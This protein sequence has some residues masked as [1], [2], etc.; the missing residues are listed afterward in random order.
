M[1]HGLYEMVQNLPQ[2]LLP[3]AAAATPPFAGGGNAPEAHLER[4]WF[5]PTE[6]EEEEEGTS[7]R[8]K[9]IA[10]D[11]ATEANT[12]PL[13]LLILVGFVSTNRRL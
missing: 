7:C 10:E 12:D 5:A 1:G 9:R 3:S 4:R 11:G 6:G 8:R 2:A 13:L